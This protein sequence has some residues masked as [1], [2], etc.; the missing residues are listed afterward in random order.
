[1][2]TFASAFTGRKRV[3]RSLDKLIVREIFKY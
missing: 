1:M 2:N 3:S